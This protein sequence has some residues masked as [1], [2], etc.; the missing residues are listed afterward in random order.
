M[1]RIRPFHPDTLNESQRELYATIVGGPR[2]A[3]G[4]G[5]HL[6]DAEG[7]LVGPFN[8][9]LLSP[10][11]GGALQE[12]GSTLRYRG[13][14]SARCRELA[15]LVVAAHWRSEFEQ[16]AHERIA[17]QV[18]LT[19]ADLA[20][21]RAGDRPALDDR[22]EAAV[23]AVARALVHSADLSQPDYEAAVATLGAAKLFE[24]TT[25]VGYYS[26]LALQMRVFGVGR[27]TE[28]GA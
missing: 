4:G 6:T 7:C 28:P 22:E 24:L 11:L 27:S 20:A 25:L 9:M 14:L 2:A 8:A 18:G 12:V 26:L 10:A 16:E 21:L 3:S 19:D 5:G 13:D 15:I 17:V 1:S 23:L